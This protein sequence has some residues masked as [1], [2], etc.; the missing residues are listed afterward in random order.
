MN[1]IVSDEALKY[2]IEEVTRL[3]NEY[4][5]HQ[6]EEEEPTGDDSFDLEK[7]PL[8]GNVETGE[9]LLQASYRKGQQD[10]SDNVCLNYSNRCCFP[11]C[12]I[13]EPTFLIG[14]HIARWSD[15]EKLRGKLSNGLCL[16]LMHDKAFESGFFTLTKDLCVAVNK[17]NQTAI[18]SKWCEKCVLPYDGIPIRCGSVKP[19]EEALSYH[20]GKIGFTPDS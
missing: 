18:T 7:N 12:P 2:F 14:S 3:L 16:C 6:E 5:N 15:V 8:I 1:D 10:F 17:N 9:G 20:W 11:H 13:D 19:S 4:R